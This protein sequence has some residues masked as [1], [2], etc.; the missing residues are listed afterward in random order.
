MKIRVATILDYEECLEIGLMACRW[1]RPDREPDEGHIG[2]QLY[3]IIHEGVIFVSEDDG[4]ITGT[5]AGMVVP[6]LWYPDELILSELY[7]FVHPDARNTSAALR[8]LKAFIDKGKELKVKNVAMMKM[9]HSPINE[10]VYLKR[11][12]RCLEEAFVMEV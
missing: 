1:L 9:H 3:K 11:G 5:I 6:N 4:K 12:F 2:L 10:D 7:W 8:L